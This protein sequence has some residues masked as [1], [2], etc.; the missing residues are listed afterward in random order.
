MFRRVFAL[1]GLFAVAAT[2]ALLVAGPAAAQEQG[3]PLNRGGYNG[4]YQGG[5]YTAP[6]PAQP[7]FVAPTSPTFVPAVPATAAAPGTAGA[8]YFAPEAAGT[9]AVS[10]GNL[11]VT[12][13]ISAPAD[14]RIEFN[15]TRTLQSG[16]RRSFVS[17]PVAAGRD[18]TY[19]VTARWQEGGR[20]VTRTRH[21]TVHAGDV[22]NIDF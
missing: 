19:D 21:L 10:A 5:G 8:A 4:F 22:V 6:A 9:G 1:T 13:N 17:P 7:F 12:V 15:G 11:P 3:W 2:A 18:F 16:P 14:A 20:E